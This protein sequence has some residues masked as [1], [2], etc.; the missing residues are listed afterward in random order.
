MWLSILQF[1]LPTLLNQFGSQLF[2]DVKDGDL[3]NAVLSALLT[4]PEQIKLLQAAL[5]VFLGATLAVDGKYGP[6]TRD[7]VK[8]AQEKLGQ[9]VDGWAGP[10]TMKALKKAGWL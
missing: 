5:N 1:V 7:A 4:D 10:A 8:Q 3:G 6:R 9:V 2:P